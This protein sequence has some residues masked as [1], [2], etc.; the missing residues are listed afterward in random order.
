MLLG[1][2]CDGNFSLPSGLPGLSWLEGA[3]SIQAIQQAATID[4]TVH[5]KGRVGDR[6]P[7]VGGQVYQLED[8]TGTIWV[9]TE[10]PIA[11]S[12]EQIEVKGWVR[13]Q[14]IPL[15]GQEYGEPYIEEQERW[16]EDG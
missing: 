11:Q 13:Y 9:I 5:L 1:T 7:L 10:Q 6:V 2:G 12:G 14:S 16:R 3:R 8:T 15:A 4:S